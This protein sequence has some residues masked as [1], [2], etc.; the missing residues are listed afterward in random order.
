MTKRPSKREMRERLNSDV[1]AFIKS[2][3]ELRQ[4]EK[5]MS[6]L[7]HQSE[8]AIAFEQKKDRTPVDD[9]LKTIDS[10]RQQLKEARRLKGRYNA[11]AT[12]KSTQRAKKKII[13]D[14]FG[15][16]LRVVWE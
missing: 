14:D 5:G 12:S 4:I 6:G 11:S 15:E 8:S 9:V 16:P 3:G 2:G 1:E 7:G 10:K 13:Y